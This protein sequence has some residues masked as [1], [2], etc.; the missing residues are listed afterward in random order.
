MDIT[1]NNWRLAV[2]VSAFMVAAT[3]GTHANAA[4]KPSCESERGVAGWL[5]NA[6]LAPDDSGDFIVSTWSAER[7]YSAHF[8]IRLVYDTSQGAEPR[9]KIWH[10]Y[11]SG[12]FTMHLHD[13]RSF[14]VPVSANFAV[15]QANTPPDIMADFRAA[16]VRIEYTT[17]GGNWSKYQTDGLP[18]AIIAAEEDLATLK[19]KRDANECATDQRWWR[20][21]TGE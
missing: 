1:K 20:R 7:D 6:G 12:H 10:N 18:H 13:G 14:T 8:G 5:V 19:E 11:K 9:L 2:A 3:P 15:T 17:A 21:F 4:G 16:P